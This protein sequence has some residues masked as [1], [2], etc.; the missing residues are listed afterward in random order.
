MIF[1]YTADCRA[2]HDDCIIDKYADDT[3]LTGQITDD[4]DSNYRHEIDDFVDCLPEDEAQAYLDKSLS[5]ETSQS[6]LQK[7]D[8][9]MP[10]M[11]MPMENMPLSIRKDVYVQWHQ[12]GQEQGLQ[13]DTQIAS[14]LLQQ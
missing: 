2:S 9:K 11:E 10:A 7:F 5:V 4:D 1:R 3:A 13:S 14:F 6:V 8:Q 12:V